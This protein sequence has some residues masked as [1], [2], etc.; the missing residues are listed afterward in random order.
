MR[1]VHGDS[2]SENAANRI[3]PVPTL[4]TK[5]TPTILIVPLLPFMQL[6]NR[7][8]KIFFSDLISLIDVKFSHLMTME[9]LTYQ[10]RLIYYT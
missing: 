6:R 7:F 3:L 4:R 8:I 9:L 5:S 2:M 10:V 1:W